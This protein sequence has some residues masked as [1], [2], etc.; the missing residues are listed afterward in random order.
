M[1]E[2]KFK[3]D[4]TIQ[5]RAELTCQYESEFSPRKCIV[6]LE[7][8]VNLN[9]I[10]DIMC[11]D[12]PVKTIN[13]EEGWKLKILF[14]QCLLCEKCKPNTFLNSFKSVQSMSD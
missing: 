3:I 7:Q 13:V 11:C 6:A 2:K 12:H 4:S 8:E 10:H 9:S 5:A 1:I 14:K